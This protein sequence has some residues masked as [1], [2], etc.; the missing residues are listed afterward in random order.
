MPRKQFPY[1][2]LS[3]AMA[4]PDD[5]VSPNSRRKPHSLISQ[6]EA[7]EVGE[8]A[9][10]AVPVS[11]DTTFDDYATNGYAMREALRNSVAASMRAAKARTGGTYEIDTSDMFT[12]GRKL[13]IVAIITRTE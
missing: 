11:P 7:L 5:D 4:K 13:F 8:C 6:I 1:N 12:T 10:K 2:Q 9:S 3:E